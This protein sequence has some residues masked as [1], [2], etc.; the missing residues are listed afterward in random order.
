MPR[1]VA[2]VRGNVPKVRI[3]N[4]QIEERKYIETLNPQVRSLSR[5]STQEN[6][7]SKRIAN[8]INQ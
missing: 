6:I 3:T 4:G 5:Q 8:E 1:R 7:R 2:Q